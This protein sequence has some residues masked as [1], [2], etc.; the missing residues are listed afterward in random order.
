MKK[1]RIQS[2]FELLPSYIAEPQLLKQLEIYKYQAPGSISGIKI[3]EEL[4]C[5]GWYVYEHTDASNEVTLGNKSSNGN[6]RYLIFGHNK[7]AIVVTKDSY[8]YNQ[9]VKT[10][11]AS[12]E[13]YKRN[14]LLVFAE[15]KA[16][17]NANALA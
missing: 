10:F 2:S 13:D 16:A 4:L 9:L 7:A 17:S 5:I 11:N 8:G 1:R 12:V 14:A 3:G 15:G 6:D